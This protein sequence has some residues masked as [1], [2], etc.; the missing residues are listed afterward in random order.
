MEVAN[1][2]VRSLRPVNKQVTLHDNSVVT[3][4]VFDA[5]AMIMDLLTNPVLMRKENFAEGYDIFAGDVESNHLANELYGEIH[6]GDE[7]LPT[8]NKYCRSPDSLTNDI[9]VA[10]VIFGDKFHTDLH[11]ALSL[12]PIIFTRNAETIPNSGECLVM[13]PILVMEKISLP[14]LQQ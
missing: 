1:P 9:P 10:L 5:K 4:P 6:M 3:A 7:W 14:K 11:R 13:S 2:L 8:R 12:T